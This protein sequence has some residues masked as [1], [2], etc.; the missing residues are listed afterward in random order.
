MV[1]KWLKSVFV[2]RFSVFD[3]AVFA[4]LVTSDVSVIF[5]FLVLALISAVDV[6]MERW[7]EIRN[8]NGNT[9][10]DDL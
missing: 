5:L 10:W 9:P 1:M 8:K 7:L 6:A 2:Q 4:L 3:L